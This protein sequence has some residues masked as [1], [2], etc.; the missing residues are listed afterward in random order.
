VYSFKAAKNSCQADSLSLFGVQWS[1]CVSPCWLHRLTFLVPKKMVY[2]SRPS[3]APD[4]TI[5][6]TKVAVPT[7]FPTQDIT[8]S[9]PAGGRAT[10]MPEARGP[11]SGIQQVVRQGTVGEVVPLR[12]AALSTDRVATEHQDLQLHC[13][14]WGTQQAP[15]GPTAAKQPNTFKAMCYVRYCLLAGGPT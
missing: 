9:L 10:F 7:K 15:E 1:C 2:A 5:K 6:A 8:H 12:S 4:T 14:K 3:N 11:R 13:A